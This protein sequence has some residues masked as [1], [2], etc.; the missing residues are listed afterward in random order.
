MKKSQLK[1]NVRRLTTCTAIV[2]AGMLASCSNDDVKNNG[3]D[4]KSTVSEGNTETLKLISGA[5]QAG[6]VELVAKTK[7]TNQER[8]L[9]YVG[10]IKPPKYQADKNWSATAIAFNADGTKAYV[11]WHSDK[12]AKNPATAWGGTVDVIDLTKEVTE[13]T[14]DDIT[15]AHSDVL[16]FNH[17]LYD[18]NTLYLSATSAVNAGT[19]GRIQLANDVITGNDIDCINFPGVS[20]NAVAKKGNDL[21]AVS[22]YTGTYGIFAAD[23]FDQETKEINAWNENKEI[24][25][26]KTFGGIANF[27]GKYVTTE[28]DKTYVLYANNGDTKIKVV[29]EDA[30]YKLGVK[31]LSASKFA[32][33][34]DP[35]TGEW[36]LTGAENTYY[37]KH[38]LAVKGDY[39]YVACGQVN[40]E[41]GKLGGLLVYDL[42]K[43]VAID[44]KYQ[45]QYTTTGVCADDKYVYAATGN[46]LRVYYW[47]ESQLKETK[48]QLVF[49]EYASEVEKYDENG[50][51][52][53]SGAPTIGDDERHS[54]NFVAVSNGYIYVA[55]G[56]SG[57]RVY[58]LAE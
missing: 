38:T 20:V 24:E 40:K 26:I 30:E 3:D 47:A 16:K 46:G 25:D 55:Y 43:G 9:E 11:T 37:G 31:L 53:S 8:R 15:S 28:G 23:V 44:S 18:N 51:P 36:S 5:N 2:L 19:V 1:F 22:G 13:I 49:S 27:G 34:Y 12:Q 58:K 39:A 7:A 33:F 35:T 14:D 48:G 41:E 45:N 54:A 52:I 29:G 21:V 17:V 50:K 56:Q 42:A 57:V 4:L 10:K 32:E 6:R